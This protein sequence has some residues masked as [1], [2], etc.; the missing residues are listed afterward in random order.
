ME[1]ELGLDPDDAARLTRL[2]LIAPLKSGRARSRAVR[3]V[4][5]DS[6]DRALAEEGLALA[7]Q[8]PSWRLERLRPGISSW[9]PGAP[10]PV[11]ATGRTAAALGHPVPEPL[12]PLAA[13]EA[14]A[15]S[16]GLATEQGPVGMTLLNGVIRAFTGEH[17]ISRVRL[18]GTPEAVEALAIA[19]AGELRLAVPR[20]SLA[21]EAFAAASGMAPPPRREGAPELPAGLS[22]A[23]AFTHAVGHLGD[24]ILYYAPKAAGGKDGTEP[25]HQMRVAVRRLRSA[26]KVFR[27]AVGSPSV[28]TVDAGLKAL[29]AKLAPTRDWDVFATET[30]AGVTAA[31][32]TEPRLER[33]LAATERRRRACH[34]ELRDFLASVDFRRLGIELACLAGA[35][36]RAVT[37]DD[38]EQEEPTVSIEEFGAR[39]LRKRRKKLMQVDDHL[40]SLEPAAL[41]KI[42]LRAKRLRY[43]AEIFAPLYPGKATHRFIRG[44]SR[45][46]DRLGA[47]NDG[48]VAATM[49]AELAGNHAFAT[50]LIL[51]FVGAHSSDTRERIDKAWQKFHRLRPFWE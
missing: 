6:P 26:I 41:H 18:E 4:W 35:P 40:V 47:L 29:A 23:E 37:V 32:P 45:L 14:R 17:R 49:L 43:A 2:A 15:V 27:R 38:S 28:E 30:A 50:G 19:L 33:L 44:L 24:V 36:D 12:V 10:A 1:L 48:A 8:R 21:T 42:R 11:L 34:D 22:V 9:P 5:H 7:E 25:V 31:F 3:I 39:M 13:F 51:G 16:Q 20:A 46:Q